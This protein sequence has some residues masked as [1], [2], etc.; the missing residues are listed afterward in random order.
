MYQRLS[1]E[2]SFFYPPSFSGQY[3][4]SAGSFV[5]IRSLKTS[6]WHCV[7]TLVIYDDDTFEVTALSVTLKAAGIVPLANNLFPARN[8]IGNIFSQNAS[9]K[10]CL[11]SV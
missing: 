3:S 7:G 6:G 4:I 10:S 9:T 8:V 5:I 11:R 1:A 2:W